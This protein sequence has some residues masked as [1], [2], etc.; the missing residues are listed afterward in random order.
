MTTPDFSTPPH[1]HPAP[2]CRVVEFLDANGDPTMVDIADPLPV[3]STY[4]DPSGDAVPV[5]AD[6]PLPVT[7]AIFASLASPIA[8]FST[9]LEASHVIFN[10]PETLRRAAGRLDSTA[11]TATYY[12]QCLN[13]AALP[14]NGAVTHL[15]APIKIQHVLGLD[16]FWSF[17]EDIPV[18]GVLASHGVTIALSTTE[19]TLTVGGAYLSIGG[20]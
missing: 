18:G 1:T 3:L 16:D 7:G 11:A 20:A 15:L 5:T 19:F 6:T 4:L 14:T 12:V 9:A 17:D 13:A 8:R 10:D 2:Q